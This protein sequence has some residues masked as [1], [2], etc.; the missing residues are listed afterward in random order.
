MKPETLLMAAIFGETSHEPNDADF[1]RSRNGKL[2]RDVL[3][4]IL[5]E[6]AERYR[7]DAPLFSERAKPMVLA[8]FGF[9]GERK[10][11]RELGVMFAITRE[12]ARQVEQRVLRMLR[13]PS[14]SHQLTTYL[15]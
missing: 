4:S 12:R 6:I 13:H 3:L 14:R 5:D 10:T 11:Y 1:Y 15:K 2:L 8:R 9:D 7:H